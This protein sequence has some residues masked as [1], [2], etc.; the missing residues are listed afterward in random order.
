MT[1]RPPQNLTVRLTPDE[2]D[3]AFAIVTKF[4]DEEDAFE[5]IMW[6]DSLDQDELAALEMVRRKLSFVHQVN[7]LGEKGGGK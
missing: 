7:H 3:A 4:L 6:F 2:I 1:L 5:L